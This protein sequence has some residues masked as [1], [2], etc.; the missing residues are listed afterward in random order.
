MMPDLPDP[1]L[2]NFMD[3]GQHCTEKED[4]HIVEQNRFEI[5]EVGFALCVVS[6]YFV[7]VLACPVS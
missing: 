5:V 2:H 4:T 6:V 1:V 7:C 3:Y